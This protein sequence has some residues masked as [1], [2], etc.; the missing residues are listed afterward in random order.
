[1]RES[2]THHV[3]YSFVNATWIINSLRVYGTSSTTYS[4]SQ[5]NNNVTPGSGSRRQAASCC[6]WLL[7][8]FAVL[9]AAIVMY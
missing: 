8:G 2:V 4:T 9:G 1:M 6:T 5:V 7:V 3:R